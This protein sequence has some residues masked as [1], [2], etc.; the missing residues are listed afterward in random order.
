[1][2]PSLYLGLAGPPISRGAPLTT[3]VWYALIS[4]C[5][6]LVPR[7]VYCRVE[8]SFHT[9]DVAMC[10]LVTRLPLAA[11]ARSG[12]NRALA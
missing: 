5:S 9:E 7:W 11:A 2:I 4:E 10:H 1:M 3:A 6:L 8:C 12:L